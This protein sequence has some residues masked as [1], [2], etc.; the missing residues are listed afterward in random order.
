M[1]ESDPPT[2]P[3]SPSQSDG[4]KAKTKVSMSEYRSRQ[5]QQEAAQEQERDRESKRLLKE[6]QCRQTELIEF[7]K[8]ELA[9]I[10]EIEV[11]QAEIARIKYEQEQ[12][13]LDQERLQ[14]EQEA[15]AKL[16]SQARHTPVAFGSDT[17]CHDEHGQELDYHDDV[18][19]TSDSQEAKSWANTSANRNATPT[20]AV[21]KMRQAVPPTW[22]R[23]LGSCR[24]PL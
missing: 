10:H 9:H 16:V 21:C 23:R 8:L 20:C 12:L 17:P 14:K 7:Q 6:E 3:V 4:T 2:R 18:P 13:R 1:S 19:A 15:N 22:K 5:L 24:D 11:Q